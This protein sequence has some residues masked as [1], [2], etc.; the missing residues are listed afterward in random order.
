MRSIRNKQTNR[1]DKLEIKPKN[2]QFYQIKRTFLIQQKP[3]I[4]SRGKRN[5]FLFTQKWEKKQQDL[6]PFLRLPIQHNPHQIDETGTKQNPTVKTR[7]NP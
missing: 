2:Y 7:R 5:I 4:Y 1:G 3:M 6:Q